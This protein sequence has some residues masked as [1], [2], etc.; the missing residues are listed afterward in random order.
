MKGIAVQ[1]KFM[2]NDAKA[3]AGALAFLRS[4]GMSW[5]SAEELKGSFTGTHSCNNRHRAL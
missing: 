3:R 5:L 2:M 4:L 1:C